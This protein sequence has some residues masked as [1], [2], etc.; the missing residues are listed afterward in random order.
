[1]NKKINVISLTLIF[2]II[3]IFI[4]GCNKA[5]EIKEAKNKNNISD[6][7]FPLTITDQIGRE[8]K[9]EALPDRI[10]SLAPGNTEILFALGLEDKIVGV[11]DYCD[12][13]ES[14][15]NKEKIGGYSD[16]NIEKIVS[17]MPD[18]IVANGTHLKQIEELEKFGIPSVV[19]EPKNID[20]ML[21]SIELVGKATGQHEKATALIDELNERIK[22]VED[23][24]SKVP[25]DNRPK[26]VYELWH[27]PIMVAGPG[28]YVDDIIQRAGGENIAK[29][30]DKEYPEYSQEMIIAKN[31]D[32]IIFSYHGTSG[33]ETVESI[34]Q[35]PG[36]DKI[37][38]IKNKKVFYVDE[39]L[40]QRASPRLV[41][42]L[43]QFTKIIH[44]E[45][46]NK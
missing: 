19:I 3:N 17:L 4:V 8:V 45:F 26:V 20:E 16:P 14:A 34:M 30:A 46:F 44:P 5:P 11:T 7:L 9:I 41:D 22:K 27:T 2:L 40:V 21:D 31:P 25:A 6:N 13:P 33:G 32:I 15:T 1:M 10:I 12:Y 35:R 43:E 38:A 42:G 29:D 24:V 37:N 18:L 36:W 39:N 28:T 23:M